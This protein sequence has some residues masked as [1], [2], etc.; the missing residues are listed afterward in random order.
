MRDLLTDQEI[1]TGANG[2]SNAYEIPASTY[3]LSTPYQLLK[4]GPALSLAGE[5]SER[6]EIRSVTI[7]GY[8]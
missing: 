7:L 2:N 3:R 1:Q 5:S 6:P 4:A 8:N